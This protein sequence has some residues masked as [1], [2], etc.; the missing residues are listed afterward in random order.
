[1]EATH[2]DDLDPLVVRQLAERFP[3][4]EIDQVGEEFVQRRVEQPHG[5]RQAV[6][7]LEHR[8]EIDDLGRFQ[9]AERS[10][11][12]RRIVAQDEPSHD[13]QTVGGEEH[14]LGPAQPDALSSELP[15]HAGVSFGVGV[16]PNLD[17]A[18]RDGVGPGEQ[19]VELRR[20]VGSRGDERPAVD[21]AAAPVDRDLVAGAQHLIADRDRVACDVH[22]GGTDDR[23]N[24]P[25]A[26]HDG[27]VTH[28]P[29]SDGEDATGRLHAE[30]V[31]GRRLRPDEDHVVAVVAGDD[32]IVGREHDPAARRS[33]RRRQ[34]LAHGDGVDVVGQRLVEER[35]EVLGRDAVERG[36]DGEPVPSS[37]R[38]VH[39]TRSVC[40]ISLH[41]RQASPRLV[42][43][44]RVQR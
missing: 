17:R 5:D 11:F 23:R 20:C 4:G 18:E 29:A 14:V 8:L 28:Q 24:P 16:G 7:R 25:S 35:A 39:G 37:R 10:G 12:G 41:G 31:V 15:R 32:R 40:E 19:R 22:H 9:L 44:D 6:H 1:M 13:L 34:P 26:G 3:Y 30:H 33:R 36:S 42:A 21:L 27:G 38:L 2:R 43:V